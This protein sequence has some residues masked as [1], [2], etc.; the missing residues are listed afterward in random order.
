MTQRHLTPFLLTLLIGFFF[1]GMSIAGQLQEPEQTELAAGEPIHVPVQIP[2]I[3]VRS[4]S[5]HGI[6]S[7][8]GSLRNQARKVC[9]R[10]M[11]RKNTHE[12]HLS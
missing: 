9:F 6:V 5:A 11:D 7:S 2:A 3:A 1:V 12:K 8:L 4:L 10:L